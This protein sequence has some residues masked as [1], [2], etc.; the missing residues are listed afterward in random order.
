MCFSVLGTLAPLLLCGPPQ[1][2]LW[3]CPSVILKGIAS[4]GHDR[5]ARSW[6]IITLWKS[7]KNYLYI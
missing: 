2:Y 5:P 3:P 6:E 4:C 1:R 7:D